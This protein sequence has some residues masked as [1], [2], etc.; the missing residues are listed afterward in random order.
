MELS[1]VAPR[2]I[3]KS[4]FSRPFHSSEQGL[5]PNYLRLSG[6]LLLAILIACGLPSF[7]SANKQ[8]P[9]EPDASGKNTRFASIPGQIIVRFKPQAAAA[10]KNLQVQQVE[11]AGRGQISMRVESL[12]ES[13]IVPGLRVAHVDPKD[14]AIAIET[15]RADP[16]VIYAEPNFVRRKQNTPA[17]QRYSDLWGLKN[18]G[19][20][21]GTPGA[22]INAEDAWDI[23][24]GNRNV[25]VAV[26]DE[27]IDVSHQDLQANIWRNPGEVA[28]NG[29]DDDAN[30]YADDVNGFD[31]FHN[32]A[33]VYD[34]P[35][36]NPDGSPV[37]AHGTH[38]AGTI[39]ATGNN[40]I[41]VV[42]VNWQTSLMSLK[43][44]GPDGGSTADL[45]KALAYAKMMRDRWV[46]S[47]GTQ[48]A[49]IR[50]T[51]NSYGGGGYSQGESD[52]IE[53]AGASGI[54]F[55]VS[56]G[57]DAQDNNVLATYPADYDLPSVISVAATN[58]QDQLANFSNKGSRTV[59]LGAP[60]FNILSTTPGNT[61]SFY[62]GTSM[63]S[64]HVAGAAAL[65]LAAHSDFSVSRLRA[66]LLFG[67]ESIGALTQTTLTGNRLDARGALQNATESDTTAPSAI[68]DLHITN[69]IGR[70]VSLAWTA[71][72]DDGGNG[73][74]ALYEIRFVDQLTGARFLIGGQK[75][76]PAGSAESAEVYIPYRHTAGAI[77][78]RTYDNAGNTASA[79]TNVSVNLDAA[80]PY[81][82]VESPATPLSTGG[83]PFHA[84]FDDYVFSY[85]LPF[86]FPFFERY[87]SGILISTNG[88]VY[89]PPA[90]PGPYD[91]DSAASHLGGF[92]M[93]AGLWDDLDLRTSSRADADIFVVQP[94]SSR[95]I[96]RWQGVPCNANATGQC[97]GGGPVNF[98][99]ELR[100]DGTIITRY[101]DGNT[102]LHPVVGIGGGEPDAYPIASHTSEAAPTD[103]T[104]AP[105]VT[106]SLKAAPAK[107]D[108]EI[109]TKAYPTTVVVGDNVTY[110]STIKNLG[111]NTATGV[112]ASNT[113]PMLAQFV[114]CS[115]SQGR[116]SG[117]ASNSRVVTAALGPIASGD[118]ATFTVIA[119]PVT[120]QG[121]YDNSATV[122]ARTYDPNTSSNLS[123]TTIS[124]YT[125]NPNPIGGMTAV[126]NGGRHSLAIGPDGYVLAWGDNTFG[127]LGDGTAQYRTET[128][129]VKGLDGV[130][131]IAA[132]GAFSVAVKPNGTVWSWGLNS[133]GQLGDGTNVTRT[134]PVKVPNLTGIT[135]ASA[136]GHTIALKSD[137]TVWTWGI[138]FTGQLGDNTTTSRSSPAMV[139][140]VTNVTEVAAGFG[141]SVVVRDDGTVWAW[142][143]NSQGQLGDG[144]TVSK[145]TP[146]QTPGI[147]GV[148]RVSAW[149]NYTLALKNDGTVWGWGS[150]NLGQ[151]GDGTIVTRSTPVQ[152]TGLTSVTAI[153]AGMAHSLALRN[154]GSVW[155]WGSNFSSQLG[156][157]M[158]LYPTN[159]L[160]A[161][162]RVIIIAGATAISAGSE[163]S[164]ALAPDGSVY[165]WG[166]SSRGYPYQVTAPAP[167]PPLESVSFSPDGG[168][169]LAAQ[170]VT[171]TLPSNPASLVSVSLGGGHS[172]AVMSDGTV[173]GWGSSQSGQIGLPGPVPS[174]AYS[175]IPVIVNGIDSVTALSGGS[176]YSLAL[177][178][179][180]TVWGWGSNSFGET[181]PGPGST[182]VPRQIPG[183]DNVTV[184]VAGTLHSMALRSDGTVWTW[185]SNQYGQLGD[186]TT[187]QRSMPGPVLGLTNVVAIA[188][189]SSHSLAVKSDGTVWAWGD[190]RH[191]EIGDNTITI[192][193]P[194]PVQVTGLTNVTGVA[195]GI[196]RSAAVRSD[197]TVWGW[198]AN[199]Y[200]AIGDGTTDLRKTPVMAVGISGAVVVRSCGYTTA[201][202]RN[203]GTVWTWGSNSSGQ[204]GTGYPPFF[205]STPAQVPGL[206]NIN[207]VS[208]GFD[209]IMAMTN[210]NVWLWGN[211][212]Y[213]QLGDGSTNIR[214]APAPF[215][216]FNNGPTI[217]YTLNG[218]TPTT[219]DPV[220]V[221]GSTVTLGQTAVLKARVFREGF[222][223][224]AIKSAAYQ[225]DTNAINDTTFFVRQHYLDFLNREADTP[226]LQFWVNNIDSC[227]ADTACR[228]V[229]RID[230][231]AAYFLSIEFQETGY[232]VHRFYQATF[233]RR[234][235]Y[236][237]FLADTQAISNN[238]IVNSPGWQERLENNKQAFTNSWV[239][240]PAFMAMYD[241]LSNA[242]FVDTLIANTRVAFTPTDRNAYV[243]VLSNNALTRAQV[244]RAIAE[245]HDFYNAEYS[246]AFVEMQYFGYL[247]RDPDAGGFNFWLTKLN[248]HGGDFRAAEMVKS[249][250]VSGEYRD[251]FLTH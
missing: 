52:A 174:A 120:F 208:L 180:G 46:N 50:V 135:T 178:T 114:S 19:Q 101:G 246:P 87:G 21:S 138:N 173:Y 142:G 249:F 203:D 128:V 111:P 154:D 237:E 160:T 33:S 35:G 106:Y 230:T 47:G 219:D 13:E 251:R 39:G 112:T 140:G 10:T 193:K 45:L 104:N 53:A 217:H 77:T 123:N 250:L 17:D 210:T 122:S 153:A 63:A 79:S 84:N 80:E 148:A 147:S 150:N 220:V 32:D 37:D 206:S 186:G 157:G 124:A 241:G 169:Y 170:P 216:F 130:K 41:G 185:G 191:G 165:A 146:I 15:L 181:G 125:P 64:P 205:S 11:V 167:R 155:A 78:L 214:T 222:A 143:D 192:S 107:A 144:T 197:G 31:F 96:F 204:L 240:R 228:E 61:Y 9:Q 132:G 195:A 73:R 72:G 136:S 234:P 67:G 218:Q 82:I 200:G 58:R 97:S 109:K 29:I 57:N 103:L 236:M 86:N 38:V 43:F 48:G 184:I 126:S 229:K 141:H 133:D 121:T 245:N 44:L 105:V 117:P 177:K 189:G 75:P 243:D 26:I 224:S 248:E 110:T 66:A 172:L 70:N 71:T 34:G 129:Y 168:S 182:N 24:T 199:D 51:N 175:T 68:G 42:G 36:T 231:S 242:Q 162:A 116:C 196:F 28:G 99:I 88:A 131:T 161:P 27:G 6:L 183:I 3:L 5:S 83:N 233:G 139:G 90:F 113:F 227:G 22:D 164:L 74:A 102:Q 215:D 40:G 158:D 7:S 207:R 16:D 94:D 92:Q 55:V 198:G 232:L 149:G 12:G 194:V 244:V 226:G 98:E 54:L 25:V 145:L 100:N 209:H 134:S 179:N 1:V 76:S 60:G 190:N 18:T 171:V 91:V 213:G 211:N 85:N 95:I 187:T 115:T 137:G 8:S 159:Y 69:Q 89:F 235:L 49:N 23:T 30:G 4:F 225:I 151:L 201:A 166:N 93:V 202:L 223:P 56:A 163:G 127:Q 239:T 2:F 238:V 81:T 119:R 188:A 59:Q 20:S 176:A 108:L 65:V 152:V 14:T 212:N 156:V 62:D 118:S 247:R 221:S